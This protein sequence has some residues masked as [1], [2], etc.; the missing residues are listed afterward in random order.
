MVF[1]VGDGQK[2]AIAYWFSRSIGPFARL[3]DL[4]WSDRHDTPLLH[5]QYFTQAEFASVGY[6]TLDIQALSEQLRSA[7]VL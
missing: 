7:C 5:G 4:K 6:P 3:H 2:Y 1:G